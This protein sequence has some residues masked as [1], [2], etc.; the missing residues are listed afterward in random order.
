V[1][2]RHR[3]LLVSTALLALGCGRGKRAK[4]AGQ[5]ATAVHAPPAP[6]G[7]PGHVH[8][9]IPRRAT[10]PALAAGETYVYRGDVAETRPLAA[11]HHD[12]L[13]DVDLGDGWAPFI[14]QDGDPAATAGD[15]APKPNAYRATFVDLA[16][17]RVDADGQ[18]AK[19]GEHNFLEV[20]GVPPTLSVL[21]ARVEDDVRP[22][23]QACF[24]GLDLEA[25]RRFNGNIG[26]LDRDRAKRDFVE[27]ARDA[28]W[29]HKQGNGVIDDALIQSLQADPKRR[30]RIDRYL[31]G[32]ARVRAVRAAQA[33]LVCDG[34]LWSTARTRFTSG[35]FDLLTHEALAEWEKKNDIF[36]WGFLG[37]ETMA[38][39]LR[40]PLELHFETFKRILAERIADAAGIV[41]DGSTAR[42]RKPAT[43]RDAAGETR[44]VPNLI[45]DHVDA[46][47]A[48]IHVVTPEEMVAF[49]R[50]QAAA[51]P[52]GL[53]WLHVAFKA[54][55]L[56]AYYTPGLTPSVAPS[57]VDGGGGG[58]AAGAPE[59]NLSVEID[60]GDVWYDVPFDKRGRPLEQRRDHY[61]HLVMFVHWN[62]QKIPLCRWRTTIGSWRTEADPD[63]RLYMKYKNSDV[64]SRV[65]KNI[66]AG[67]VWIP[68]DGTPVRDL[69]TRKVLD[70]NVGPVTLVKTDVMGPG[71]ASAYGMVMAIHIDP[72]RGGFDNQ[73]RTH[74]SVDYTSIAR[75]FSH[76]CHRLVNNRAVRLFDF[77]L[78]HHAFHR[79]G[80][81]PLRV[82]KRFTVDDKSY[83]YKLDTRGYYYELAHPIPVEV[84]EGR[85]M[86]TVKR[87]ITAFVRKPG[88]DY[89]APSSGDATT[90]IAVP[91]EGE[92]P[93]P[94]EIEPPAPPAAIEGAHELGP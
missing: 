31:R 15:D 67:P 27:A 4:P 94:A 70:T 53:A 57:P 84:T 22:V 47:L 25:L 24:D 26:Y 93:P 73:I 78:K 60:R 9:A 16:N 62:D 63:G 52:A 50:A 61:P 64:G 43:Y 46:L 68:P 32:Q 37:G 71:F 33:Y 54:P 23:K 74:G 80:D 69:L 38:N 86:G 34:L 17:D 35:M 58:G 77:V 40:P 18:K 82:R 42:G 20:F 92:A 81:V 39:L 28:E 12:G 41:E 19:R 90:S 29:M 21:A 11:A 45:Q 72:K 87:P 48:A 56:P 89:S 13:L 36:G 10:P 8:A 88:V 7:P 2:R 79:I 66:V 51:A 83:T 76:G 3:V 59:M 65:W 49:L 85:I 14:L 75:R 6:A 55:P 1:V 91:H 44:L 5:Q 30:G